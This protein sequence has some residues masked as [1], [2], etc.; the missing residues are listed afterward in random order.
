[1]PIPNAP[2]QDIFDEG[3]LCH[4]RIPPRI[5]SS[6]NLTNSIVPRHHFET[7]QRSQISQRRT[8]PVAD[9]KHAGDNAN[10][11]ALLMTSAARPAMRARPQ[12]PVND[13]EPQPAVRGGMVLGLISRLTSLM[14]S[15][16][17]GPLDE[18]V[19]YNFNMEVGTVTSR[20]DMWRQRLEEERTNSAPSYS[21]S[22]DAGSPRRST[23]DHQTH[24]FITGEIYHLVQLTRDLATSLS[25]RLT[26]WG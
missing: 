9:M 19:L 15:R 7:G 12:R 20:V 16:T 11:N 6:P 22:F 23:P 5:N 18:Q 8:V 4:E 13:R 14:P 24:A 1:M 21:L 25:G 10:E 17:L 3:K 2:T 26:G